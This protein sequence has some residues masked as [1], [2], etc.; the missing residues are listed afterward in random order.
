MSRLTL[1]SVNDALQQANDRFNEFATQVGDDI[2]ALRAGGIGGSGA[3]R[4][5][6]PPANDS[7]TGQVGD[8]S[9]DADNAYFCYATNKWGQVPLITQFTR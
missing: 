3:F 5:V 7:S 1:K 6:P 4:L 8:V 9:F 2:Q